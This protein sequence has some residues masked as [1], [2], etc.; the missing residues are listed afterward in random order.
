MRITDLPRVIIEAVILAAVA[1]SLA[2]RMARARLVGHGTPASNKRQAACGK[3]RAAS[4]RA[5]RL[6]AANAMRAANDAAAKTGG[7]ARAAAWG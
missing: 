7:N 2:G 1:V 5:A 4:S 6:D 3:T